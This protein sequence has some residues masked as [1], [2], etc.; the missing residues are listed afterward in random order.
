[1]A[2]SLRGPKNTIIKADVG[3]SILPTMY[4]GVGATVVQILILKPL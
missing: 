1:V 4:R 2:V 3:R